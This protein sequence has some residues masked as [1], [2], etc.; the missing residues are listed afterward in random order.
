MKKDSPN[1]DEELELILNTEFPKNKCKERGHA[2]VLFAFAQIKINKL[3]AKRKFLQ[4]KLNK[5]KYQTQR[6]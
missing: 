4:D 5:L 2:L 6:F 1:I 3:K